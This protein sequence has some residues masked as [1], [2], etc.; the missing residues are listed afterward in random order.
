MSRSLLAGSILLLLFSGSILHGQNVEK[1][2]D[3]YKDDLAGNED[4]ERVIR[5][6]EGRGEVGDDSQPTPATVA[7]EQFQLDEGLAIDLVASEPEIEQPLSLH[8]DDRGRLW[9]VEYRQYP[10][11]EG[12]KVIRY[13]QHLRAVFDKVPAAPPNHVRG[14]D[15]ISLLEDSD[16]DGVYDSHRVVIDG[17]NIASSVLTGHGGIW[18]LNPPYLLFYPDADGDAVPDGDPVVHL[19]GFG[20][21]DTH[22]VA[23]S[24]NW[25]PDGWI[26]AANGS[27]TTGKVTSRAGSNVQWEGQNIWRYNPKTQVFEIYAEGGGNT[28]STEIDSVGRVF[29]GTNHGNTRGMYYPQGSYGTK[30]WGKH[31]PLTNPFAFGFFQHMGHEGDRDRFAQTFVIYEG[32]TLPERFNGQ[33]I[34]ANALHNRVWASEL[35]SEG[36]TYRTVDLPEVATTDDRW[37]RPVDLKV[38]PDGAVYV[39]DWYDTRLTHVDPRDNWHKSSGRIYRIRAADSSDSDPKWDLSQ[40]SNMELIEHFDHP[41]K[42]IKQTAVRVLGERLFFTGSELDQSD[43]IDQLKD[44]A[45]SSAPGALEALWALN[46]AGEFDEAWGRELLSHENPHIR[47]WVIR[48]LGDQRKVAPSTAKTLEELSATEPYIQVRSQLASSARRFETAIALPLIENLLKNEDDRLDPHMPLMLWWAIEGHTGTVPL[49]DSPQVGVLLTPSDARSPRDQIF[50][51]LSDSSLWELQIVR[52]TILPRLMKRFALSQYAILDEETEAS[53]L[54]D[55]ERLLALAPGSETRGILLASFLES[56]QGRDL[57]EIPNQLRQQILEHQQLVGKS[58]LLLN[59]RLGEKQALDQA[60]NAVESSQ[61][62]SSLRLALIKEFGEGRHPESVAVLLKLLRGSYGSTIK[63]AA[64]NSLMSFPDPRIGTTICQLYHSA[65]PDEHG[66]RETAH[67]VLA[68]RPGW[69]EQL[70][71]EVDAFRIPAEAI[72]FDVVNQMRLH[73]NP[74]VDRLIQKHWG[75]VR[76]TPEEKLGEIERLKSL[77]TKSNDQEGSLAKGKALF[78]KHCGVCHKIFDEG[79]VIGPNL[80]GY[81]RDNLD[82]MLLAIVDPSAG[83]REEFTQYQ[84]ATVDGRILTGL[85]EDQTPATVVMRHADNSLT[86]VSRESI[87]VLQAIAT[88]I[89]PDGVTKQLSDEDLIDLFAFLSQPTPVRPTR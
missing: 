20:L 6:F 32:G 82:F 72:G 28:F 62:D 18:V 56:Y 45:F 61:T 66:I 50:D 26:Y 23:N 54:A 30:N 59:L 81:E 35:I 55:C 79:G 63:N 22:S 40:L 29:S 37:F 27:T 21:E 15:R 24:L 16:A 68:S 53:G 60:L 71:A 64:M 88:S 34:A 44:L 38:G 77:L 7:V 19:S 65:L 11:P 49:N 1:S 25:G 2:R 42:F 51:W 89:M 8:F 33:V 43:T 39:A 78:A 87:Q 12:L 52:E 47:R 85:I 13:D 14:R 58:D 86:E 17:L 83:I 4:V 76:S 48:L 73:A 31:G 67:R 3:Q 70:L 80:T 75:R 41:N 10:F 84:I 69:S 74:E 46:W 9:V 36:S 57:T 5:S